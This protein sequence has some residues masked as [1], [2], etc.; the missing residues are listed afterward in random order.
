MVSRLVVLP[1]RLGPA[2]VASG[3]A[4]VSGG[5]GMSIVLVLLAVIVCE[6]I[7]VQVLAMRVDVLAAER[8]ALRES[9]RQARRD[10]GIARRNA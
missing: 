4:V 5:R 6:F 3:L 9:L 7:Y 1:F 10:A 2:L 8:D